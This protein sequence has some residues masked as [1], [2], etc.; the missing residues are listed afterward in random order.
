MEF[1]AAAAVL[2]A[3][4]YWLGVDLTVTAANVKKYTA[5]N[6]KTNTVMA[7]EGINAGQCIFIDRV[8]GSATL[9]KA[10][11]TDANASGKGYCDGIALNT[12]SEDQ[13]C[14]YI[15]EGDV[16]MGATLVVGTVYVASA[17]PGGAAPSTDLAS[18]WRVIVLGT[19]VA[20]NK[21]RLISGIHNP[22]ISV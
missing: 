5:T 3:L 8:V 20:I 14:N 22:N 7:G 17:T 21:L 10:L 4:V 18:G 13:P 9:N 19:A 1:I 15:Y 16:D 12:A 6:P 2:V 11:L